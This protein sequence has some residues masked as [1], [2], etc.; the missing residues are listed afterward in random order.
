MRYFFIFLAFFSSLSSI[1]HSELLIHAIGDSHSSE[2]SQ[3]PNCVCHWVG[4]MTMHRVGRDGLNAVNL[5]TIGVQNNEVAVFC[6]GEID[7][8]CHICNQRD[9]KL[10]DLHEIIETLVSNYIATIL[11]NKLFYE[12]ITCI[13]YSVTPPTNAHFN[14]NYPFCGTLED[15]VEVTKKL[16]QKLKDLC[17]ENDIL[18]LDVYDAYANVDGTLNP[19]LSD[20]FVHINPSQNHEIIKKLKKL[21]KKI[22]ET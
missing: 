9:L 8:R 5:P 11:L 4:P 1:A 21:I 14:P 16:N 12:K 6:F 20:G 19:A 10:R 7:V 22:P 17:D 2:F 3:V 15:R 13:V 18:F